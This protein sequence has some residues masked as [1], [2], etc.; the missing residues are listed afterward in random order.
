VRRT[1][2]AAVVFDRTCLPFELQCEHEFLLIP[3]SSYWLPGYP[4]Q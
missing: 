2:P 1:W 3:V 4:A